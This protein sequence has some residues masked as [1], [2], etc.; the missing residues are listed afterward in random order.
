MGSSYCDS[1]ALHG[2]TLTVLGV[3]YVFSLDMYFKDCETL[4]NWLNLFLSNTSLPSVWI[5]AV[6][7][8]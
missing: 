6:N 5:A 7:E 2:Y 4:L 1:A 8:F 3:A